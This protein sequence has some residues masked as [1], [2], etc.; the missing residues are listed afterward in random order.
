M[1]DLL[2][3]LGWRTR[4]AEAL[5]FMA[6]IGAA[7]AAIVALSIALG[8]AAHVPAVVVQAL[9]WSVWLGWLR[10]V[11]PRRAR[12]RAICERPYHL[13]FVRELL[14]GIG[15]N[16][17]LLLRPVAQGVVEGAAPGGG[18][19]ALIGA[20]LVGCGAALIATAT[21][22][23]GIARAFFVHEYVRQGGSLVRSGIYRHI[24]HPL[25]LG[26]LALSLGF[27]LTTGAHEAIALALVNVC[28]LPAY[29]LCEES[30]CTKV[31]GEPY[32]AY[33]SRSGAVLPRGA[34]RRRIGG[35]R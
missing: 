6:T 35:R 23:I 34:V 28:A 8:M 15:G 14:P 22:E 20:C 33:R 26:G 1:S 7:T 11:F 18:L 16:F 12:A 24:R 19:H 5:R 32:L 13:A 4:S 21:T 29:V 9:M 30:R 10:F 2:L 31:I 27:A 17:A 25:F 3:A